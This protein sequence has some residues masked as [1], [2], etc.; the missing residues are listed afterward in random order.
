[1]DNCAVEPCE[2]GATC[3]DKVDGFMCHCLPGFIG[4]TCEIDY[5]DCSSNPCLN[6]G[7]CIGN[8]SHAL[9]NIWSVHSKY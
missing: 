1:M 3:E 5:D 6:G 4:D 2:N 8:K 7:E 9:K